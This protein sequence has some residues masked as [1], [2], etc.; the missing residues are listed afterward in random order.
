MNAI[1][2]L[3]HSAQVNFPSQPFS[4]FESPLVL[5]IAPHFGAFIPTYSYQYEAALYS[6]VGLQYTQG[7]LEWGITRG[8]KM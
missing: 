8:L 2:L 5:N 3:T 1:A 4:L 7:F 6:A